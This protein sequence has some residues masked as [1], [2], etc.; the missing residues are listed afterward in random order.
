MRPSYRKI[1]KLLVVPAALGKVALAALMA[2]EALLLLLAAESAAEALEGARKCCG[3]YSCIAACLV[4][5]RHRED[6]ARLLH[7]AH[8]VA[9][10]VEAE[11]YPGV[12]VHA[13]A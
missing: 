11:A 3:L 9:L 12:Q 7:A 6:A 2:A 4:L 5:H 8:K 1:L 10:A 13:G